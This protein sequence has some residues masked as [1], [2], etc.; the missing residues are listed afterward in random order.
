[1]KR[2]RIVMTLGLLG[3]VV[4][5][6]AL[7]GLLSP[8]TVTITLVNQSPTFHVDGTLV[9]AEDE[10]PT[11]LL[12]Q[13]GTDVDFDLNPG[14][15]SRLTRDCDQVKSLRL[16]DADLRVITGISPDTSTEVLVLGDDFDCGDEIVF[17]F[18]HTAAIVDFDV[19]V[20]TL[21]GP[22]PSGNP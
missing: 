1:M 9:T 4:G 10:L 12:D 8:T 18:S 5:C 22:F 3:L 20:T 14:G 6:D 7:L 17:T 2:I 19:A 15:V 13:L 21:R 16:K 11:A